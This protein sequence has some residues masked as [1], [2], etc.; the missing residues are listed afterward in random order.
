MRRLR[1]IESALLVVLIPLSSLPGV[2]PASA[3][4]LFKAPFPC[5]Q[6]W[7]ASTYSGHSTNDN[8]VDFNRYPGQSDLGQPALADAP[9]NARSFWDRQGGNMVEIDHGGGWKTWY[10]H[11]A[12]T[13]INNPIDTGEQIGTVGNTTGGNPI[14]P[15]LHYEQRLNNLAQP[16]RFDGV[17]IPVGRSYTAN[18]PTITSTN[19]GATTPRDGDFVS[20][21]GDVFRIAGGAPIW[22]SS[23]ANVGGPQPTRA[24]SGAEFA[25]LR[26][27]PADG[28]FI[29]GVSRGEIYRVVGG[30]PIYVTYNWWQNINPKPPVIAVDQYAIDR[31]GDPGLLS[32]LNF[33]PADGTFISAPQAPA[34]RGEVYRIAGGAPVYVTYNWWQN[35]N[36]KP[37]VTTVSQEAIDQAG[38][39]GIWSH[40]NH[41]PADGTFISAPQAPAGRGEVYRIAGGAPVYVTYNWWQNINPKPPVTTVSQEAIDQAGQPGAWS[42]LRH[43]PAEGTFISSPQAPAGRGEVYRIAGGAPI[44]VSS[45]WWQTLNPKPT[46]TT[47]SQEAIDQ[48]GKQG[49]WSHIN[50]YPA[51]NTL[52]SA[53]G[54]S[55]LIKAAVASR[56]SPRGGLP[57]DPAALTNAGKPGAWSHLKAAPVAAPPPASPPASPVA[58][59]GTGQAPTTRQ[60]ARVKAVRI[61]NLTNKRVLIRWKKVSGAKVYRIKIG[62]ESKP[63]S[64]HFR[65]T[66]PRITLAIGSNGRY[67]IRIRAIGRHGKLATTKKNFRVRR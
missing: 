64:R 41:N 3:A 29:S 24:L 32:H 12:T 50:Y 62:R 23:W 28:T 10:A 38:Q 35:I 26:Q 60:G 14:S 5:G 37:P 56:V 49:A 52:V 11:L 30:A 4:P 48:A 58:T 61:K 7:T 17:Q 65:T 47:V 18:D 1:F 20:Y 45:G 55:Y 8:A 15:H 57:I 27:Q 44:Y 16:V 22:V 13:T 51:D 66:K 59:P 21:N 36:P 54:V 39:N 67:A 53:A 31:A 19:C 43:K 42:H 25:A 40:L 46:V 9:G 34:G 2:T 63:L 33:R 6:S